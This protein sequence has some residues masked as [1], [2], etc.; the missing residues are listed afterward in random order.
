MN[1][2][3]V[4]GTVNIS[5]YMA[6]NKIEKLTNLVMASNEEDAELKFR[7]HYSN[8]TQEYCEYYSVEW[9]DVKETIT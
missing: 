4:E 8:K 7:L 6:G 3:L 5:Y 9:V 2:Y 1:C